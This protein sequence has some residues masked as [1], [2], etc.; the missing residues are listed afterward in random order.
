MPI[1]ASTLNNRDYKQ[2]LLSTATAFAIDLTD[3]KRFLLFYIVNLFFMNLKYLQ[4][5]FCT[6]FLSSFELPSS[7]EEIGV[8]RP[9]FFRPHRQV[10]IVVHPLNSTSSYCQVISQDLCNFLLFFFC[11]NSNP[12]LLFFLFVSIASFSSFCHL[13]YTSFK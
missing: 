10:P 6:H 13:V 12:L 2:Q 3:C 8:S 5:G 1:S 4:P 9:V 11:C 7:P